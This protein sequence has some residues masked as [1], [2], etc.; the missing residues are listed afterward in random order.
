M[1][2]TRLAL[3]QSPALLHPVLLTGQ[4]VAPHS[5]LQLAGEPRK[6]PARTIPSTSATRIAIEYMGISRKD[7]R[8]VYLPEHIR[9][10]TPRQK[11]V[12]LAPC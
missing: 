10:L 12:S 5:P 7:R 4:L 2:H 1:N 9:T 6:I 11:E 3:G 8:P